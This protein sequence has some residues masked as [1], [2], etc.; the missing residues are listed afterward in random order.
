[1]RLKILLVDDEKLAL[2]GLRMVA[3]AQED[4]VSQVYT[5]S[6]AA[7]ARKI[8]EEEVIDCIITDIEMP[9]GSGLSLLRWLR[10]QKLE[11]ECIFQTCHESFAF[12][13]EALSLG[14]SDYL[15]KP[16]Q[17]PEIREALKKAG[18]N[19]EQRLRTKNEI[20]Y[21]NTMKQY[22]GAIKGVFL[23]ELLRGK[24]GTE[25]ER[26]LAHYE[27]NGIPLEEEE[28]VLLLSVSVKRI[29]KSV[30]NW[31]KDVYDFAMRNVIGESMGIPE[32]NR[33]CQTNVG[34]EINY[35]V[36]LL[37]K[38][39]EKEK[40]R[41]AC[42]GLI[43][44]MHNEF[45]TDIQVFMGDF[46][47]PESLPLQFERLRQLQENAVWLDSFCFCED[48]GEENAVRDI[49]WQAW[50]ILLKNGKREELLSQAEKYV[51]RICQ[52]RVMTR[53][54]LQQMMNGIRK[55]I[56][57][58]EGE[59]WMPEEAEYSRRYMAA[60]ESR[61]NASD[62]FRWMILRDGQECE[63]TVV[64]QIKEFIAENINREITRKMLEDAIHLNRDYLNRLFKKETGMSLAEYIVEKKMDTARELLV[65]T[66]LSVG[67]VGYWVGYENFSYFSRYFKKI[68]GDSPA[69]Y[70]QKYKGDN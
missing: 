52:G 56:K 60:L 64:E 37:E 46:S 4:L 25:R 26:L 3:E 13:R 47:A 30:E 69:S 48:R 5:A 66:D 33:I 61:E 21:A 45:D 8:I 40:L 50:E 31:E 22:Q 53:S 12:A 44:W 32:K 38:E 7:E 43:R 11:I 17:E 28:M 16:V 70:R 54:R 42:R 49:N 59:D 36:L 19:I 23:T 10:E 55:L 14:S 1:M 51:D 62:F 58:E 57:N 34:T 24:F 68:T 65:M 20:N 41:E 2:D 39:A 67:E 63:K 29:G 35:A 18:G 27:A 6:S 15:V 9:L